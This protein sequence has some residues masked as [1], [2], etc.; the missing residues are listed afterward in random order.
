LSSAVHKRLELLKN[1]KMNLKK[2]FK[3]LKQIQVSKEVT[4]EV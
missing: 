3:L 4:R 2:V 1:R